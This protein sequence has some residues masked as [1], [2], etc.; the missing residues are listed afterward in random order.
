MSMSVAFSPRADHLYVRVEGHLELAA[1]NECFVRVLEAVEEH[2]QL[3]VIVDCTLLQ[4]TM[5]TMD[6]FTHSA[7]A[8]E[9]FARLVDRGVSPDTRFAY[10]IQPPAADPE[11]FGETVA[12][13]RGVHVRNFETL[14]PA[15]RWLG[16]NV[17]GQ[18][19]AQ[20]ARPRAKTRGT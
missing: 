19:L 12:V 5:P 13:N 11:H 16:L 15:Y 3:R 8:A 4:G 20:A 9:Q 17:D 6:R 18:P 14:E 10:V 2:D 7:F 1:A